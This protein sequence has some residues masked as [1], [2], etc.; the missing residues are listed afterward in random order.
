MATFTI[1]T[2]QSAVDNGIWTVSD[3]DTLSKAKGTDPDRKAVMVEWLGANNAVHNE[4]LI[5]FS[6]QSAFETKGFGTI[7]LKTLWALSFSTFNL[8]TDW[9][10]GDGHSASAT[11][12]LNAE[13][14]EIK[15][16]LTKVIAGKKL[17]GIDW[18][19]GGKA[20][21]REVFEPKA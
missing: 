3:V 20:H 1:E 6:N 9:T 17:Q 5:A 19:K 11:V 2:V 8:A 7:S 4:A 21:F 16:I 10:D 18:K 14:E 15:T 12:R 13:A